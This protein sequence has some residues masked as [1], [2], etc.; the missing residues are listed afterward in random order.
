MDIAKDLAL[1]DLLC[2]EDFPT[3]DSGPRIAAGGPGYYITPLGTGPW[4]SA[5]DLYAYEV[6]LMQRYDERWGKALRWGGVTLQERRRRGEHIPEP[7]DVLSARADDLRTWE[8][9][10]TG[11]W[12]N[13][14]VADRNTEEEPELLLMVT[15]ID[16]P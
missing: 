4:P 2:T 16:P 1:T 8:A 12:V 14:A 7:W 15:E 5:D 3:A 13:L 9:T 11:R 6:A 10:G